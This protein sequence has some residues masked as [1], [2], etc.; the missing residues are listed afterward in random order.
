M[1]FAGMLLGILMTGALVLMGPGRPVAAEEPPGAKQSVRGGGVT[2]D[3][4]LLAERGDDPTFLVVLDTHSVDLDSYHF[5]EIVR[6]R[7]G[8]GGELAPTAVEGAEG[9]GHH[10]KATVRFAWPERKPKNLELVVKGVAGI[11]VRVFRWALH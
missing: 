10:R 11:P 6:L 4:T 8:R 7:D 5:E 1:G 3:V 9:S 2:V